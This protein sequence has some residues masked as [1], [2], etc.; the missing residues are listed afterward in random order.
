[1][2]DIEKARQVFEKAG[3]AF[4]TI[5]EKLAEQ[6]KEQS[7]WV[8]STRPIDVWPYLLHSYVEEAEKSEVDDYAVLCH[9]GH[10]VNSYAIHYYLVQDSLRMFLQLG[11]GGIYSDEGKDTARIRDCFLLADQISSVAK[12]V[13]RFRAGNHLTV[14]VSN[15]GGSYWL[16]PGKTR[17]ENDKRCEDPLAMLKEV[18]AWV[19]IEGG[20]KMKQGKVCRIDPKLGL[21]QL[22]NPDSFRFQLRY[23]EQQIEDILGNLDN[24]V[25]NTKNSA[26]KREVDFRL[27]RVT[28]PKLTHEED[29]WERAIY[30]K[31]GPAG[32]GEFVSVCK[33]IQ[34]YQIPL[35]NSLDDKSWG[36]VDLLGIG[37]DFM[38][39]P[40]ELKK[41]RTNE[42]PLRM[43]AEVAAYG[44]AIREVWPKLRDP[45]I[46]AVGWF[47][48]L[49][50]Q[51]PATMERVTLLGV[52]PKEYWLRCLGQL[53]GTN[54][55]KF[56]CG[57]WPHFWELVDALEKK[58]FDIHFVSVKG[59]WDDTTARPTITGARL[60][61]LRSLTLS[62]TVAPSDSEGSLCKP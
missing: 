43:L 47:G 5:P 30:K 3:L 20:W 36:Y 42:S 61:D 62:S 40:I 23:A 9:A 17:R 19:K 21:H 8:F 1:M 16:P 11:W 14:V 15:F 10:G 44:F 32:S 6:L 59:S 56:P 13:G 38:P 49:P 51:F 57:A 53:P 41:R 18:L 33:R 26:P 52:A 29:K 22:G 55:G 35:R 2:S 24:L 45:W 50:S 28:D 12:T 4:P 27:E 54:Q 58:C 48:G 39:V 25:S 37:R 46:E 31:W 7:K 60:L 34:A